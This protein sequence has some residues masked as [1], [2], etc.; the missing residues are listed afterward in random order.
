[1]PMGRPPK[2]DY[3]KVIEGDRGKGRRPS[4]KNEPKPKPIAPRMPPGLPEDA[5]KLWKKIGPELEELNLLTTIDGPAFTMLVLHYSFAMKAM[6]LL[7]RDGVMAKGRGDKTKKHPAHQVFR[8][9]SAQVR[10]YLSEFGMTPSS[11]ARISMP[12]LGDDDECPWLPD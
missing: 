9:H 10:A 3:L 8:D 11:R 1:M 5:Q 12:G 7:K 6:R 4:N 2:P